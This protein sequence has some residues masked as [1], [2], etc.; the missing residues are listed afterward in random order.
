MKTQKAN[1]R[2]S[3]CP[4]SEGNP[5]LREYHDREWGVPV[6]DDRHWYEKIVLDGAQAGLSWLIILRKRDGYREAF[7]GF[8]PAKVARFGA[9]DIARLMRNPG[10]VRNRLKVESAVKNARAFLEIQREHGSFD[11]YIWGFV[12]GATLQNRFRRQRDLPA[13]TPVAD[14]LSKDLKRRGFTF[15]GPTIVYAFMQAA[16]LVNDHLVTCFRHHE[17]LPLHGSARIAARPDRF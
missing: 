14:A 3:R 12:D 7:A 8:D 17:V 15:V 9:R 1:A 2:M 11:A 16:G 13:R 10:I 4:W 5:L 6:H